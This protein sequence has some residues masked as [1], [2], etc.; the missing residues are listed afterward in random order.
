MEDRNYHIKITPE[1]IINKI[2]PVIWTGGTIIPEPFDDECCDFTTTTTTQRITG[3]TYE[4]RTMQEL[5]SGGTNG[6]SLLTGLT[7]PIFLTENTVDMGYYSEFDGLVSQKDMMTNFIFSSTTDSP[8]TYHLYNTSDRDVL[9]YLSF[10]QYKID[11][12]DGTPIQLVNSVAPVFYS[13][14]YGANGEYTITMSGITP[15]GVNLVKKDIFVPYSEVTIT[16][17]KG[18]AYFYPSG[19]NWSA[20]PISYD[21]IYSGDAVCDIESNLTSNYTT[22]P[23]LITGYTNST[24]KDIEQYGANKYLIGI[25]VTGDTGVVGTFLG[26]DPSGKYTAYTINDID[27]YDFF[28]GTTLFAVYS[29]G[30]TSDMLICSAITKNEALINVIAQPEIYSNVFIERGRNSALET[31]ERLGEVDNVGDLV[32]YGYKF[33]KI[34]DI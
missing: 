22:V 26:V 8:Y 12:G 25:Q 5:V 28:D 23:F 10:A 15:F 3:L 13:H 21:Y 18:E 24:L 2:F 29:S 6:T 32:K 30:I 4:Y 11:W 17:P 1:V 34:K 20:T 27:Y 16:N 19:G 9:N 33:F 31:F 14:V 7:I